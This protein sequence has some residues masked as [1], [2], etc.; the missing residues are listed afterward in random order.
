MSLDRVRCRGNKPLRTHKTDAGADLVTAEA[1][2]LS[3]GENKTI[4]T[5]TAIDLPE[6]YVGLI[7]SRSGLGSKGIRVRNSVGVIDPEYKS[8]MKV[9]LENVSKVPHR[10]EVGDRIAQLLIVPI[11]TPKFVNGRGPWPKEERGGFGSTGTV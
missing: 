10:F 9:S 11:A 2:T 4:E 6:G 8:D 7:V 1:F 3:P 5:G